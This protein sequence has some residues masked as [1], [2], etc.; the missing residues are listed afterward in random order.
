[1][2]VALY[3]VVGLLAALLVASAGLKLSGKPDV[4]ES[5]ARVGVDRRRLPI[6]ATVLLVGAAGLVSGLAWSPLGIAAAVGLV[7][8]FALAVIAHATHDDLAHAIT[9]TLILCSAIGALVL[10]VLAP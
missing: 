1:V 5:Y 3:V 8:Y 10:F 2:N 7:C 9:P 6:L 4:V